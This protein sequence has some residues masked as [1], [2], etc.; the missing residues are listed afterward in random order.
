M[1]A[2]S[3]SRVRVY[4]LKSSIQNSIDEK[5]TFTFEDAMSFVGANEAVTA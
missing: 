4:T 1:S 2:L 3:A 5:S